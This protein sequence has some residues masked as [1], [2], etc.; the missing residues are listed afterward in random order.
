MTEF[1]HLK[2]FRDFHLCRRRDGSFLPPNGF[3]RCDN[4]FSLTEEE[5]D[6]L[7][8]RGYRHDIDL[9]RNNEREARP[10][11][12]AEHP[13]FSY[14]PIVMN[15][16]TYYSYGDVSQPEAIAEAYYSKL[17]VS[18]ERIAAVFR[19]FAREE[20]G[21]LFHCESG[22][23]RTGTI[24]ALLLL[25]ADVCDEDICEDYRLTYDC[26]YV[27]SEPEL[28]ADPELIPYARNMELF[29]AMFH[30]DYPCPDRYFLEIGLSKTEIASLRKKLLGEG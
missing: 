23:D 3:A 28:L 4:P 7:K 8:K 20:G 30:R 29:L 17:K 22:K 16:A 11:C 21:F 25:L 2:N 5:I 27:E 12:L 18:A 24:A 19:V 13:A 26:M 10:D 15:D 14:Y 6:T 1:P 9:R